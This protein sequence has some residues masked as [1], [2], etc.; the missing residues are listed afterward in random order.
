MIVLIQIVGAGRGI[1]H[2]L[3]LQTAK[4]GAEVVCLDINT[5]GN[6]ETVNQCRKAKGGLAKAYAYTCD[7][8]DKD[9]VI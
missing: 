8:T 7:V 3:A 9:Q 6:E 5:K 1:G 2:E 4:L